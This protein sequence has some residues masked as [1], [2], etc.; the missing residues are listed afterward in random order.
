[1]AYGV[2]RVV[3]RCEEANETKNLGKKKQDLVYL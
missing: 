1:M 3:Q 2:M